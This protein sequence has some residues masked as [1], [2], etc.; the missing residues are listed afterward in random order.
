MNMR[1]KWQQVAIPVL[2]SLFLGAGGMYAGLKFFDEKS[3]L[4]NSNSDAQSTLDE[5]DLEKIKRSY[6]YITSSYVEDVDHDKIIE[7][8]IRGMI[9]TLEDPYSVYMDEETVKQ[10]TESLDSSF[11]GIGAE[12]SMQN[13]KVTIVAPFKDSPA[14]KAGLKPNDKVITIDNEPTEGMDLHEA[15]LKIRGKKGTYVTL[16]IEREGHSELIE[17]K[18][19]RDTIPIE[20]VYTD[21]KKVNGKTIGIIEITSFSENTAK[22]FEQALHSLE[23]D[24]IDGLIIDVRGN[25]GG[26]LQ[27]VEEIADLIIPGHKPFIQI[28]DRDGNRQT[29]VSSLKAK[30][31]Y[32]IVGLIDEGSA[33]ASE[34]LAAALKENAGYELVGTKTFGKGTVQ[35]TVKLGDGS[36][37]KL[38]M[39]KWLT[40]DG[41]WIHEK[42]IQPT[43]NVKQPEF[44]YTSPLNVTDKPLEYDMNDE[45]IRSAQLMLEGLGFSP[46]RKDG[47]FNKQ[48]EQA[49]IAFQKKY[50]LPATGKID[51]ATASKLQEKI[52]ELIRSGEQ[53]LQL[54]TALELISR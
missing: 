49:V 22:D 40:P 36:E 3:A 11:E 1:M 31:P 50:D 35:Q 51:E 38:T 9:S 53:D 13:G 19:K 26:Y 42:G 46:G 16:G 4:T 32:P 25:P 12:V 23:K 52:F 45:Q 34:I 47:Y 5:N 54:Q 10:F 24:K 39:F 30:K 41:N 29:T 6:E 37:L 2:I 14:E 28:E 20:T 43:V 15:V 17:I 44:Y 18:V 48:T 27:S 8:A 21:K 7:G 33:S